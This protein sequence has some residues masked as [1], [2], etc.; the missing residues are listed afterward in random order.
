[1]PEKEKFWNPYRFVPVSAPSPPPRSAP[2]YH[3][4]LTGLSGT[5]ECRLTA[6]TALLVADQRGGQG[7]VRAFWKANDGTPTIPGTSLKGML[8]SFLEIVAPGCAIVADEKAEG[9][10]ACRDPRALCPVCALFGFVGHGNTGALYRGHVTIGDARLVAETAPPPAKWEQREIYMATPHPTHK[11]FYPGD[12]GSFRKLYH[13]QPKCMS[14]PA[15]PNAGIKPNATL[16]PA[17]AGAAFDFSIRF[18]GLAPEQL[19]MMLYAV[20]LERDVATSVTGWNGTREETIRLRGDLCHKLGHGKPVGLGS[21]QIAIQ[22]SI[23]GDGAE[24]Y[25]RGVPRQDLRGAELDAWH[26]EQAARFRATRSPTFDA[27]LRRMMVFDESDPRDF[28]YPTFQWF[29]DGATS[30]RRL[31]PA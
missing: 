4:R 29:H 5:L 1:M 15:A 18:V 3:H 7:S 16:Q 9:K 20:V 30:S 6:K 13:H 27:A 31:K 22:S 10:N 24:R 11:A 8:R 17:P 21:C 14:K 2:T 23:V 26:A 25:R 28:R 12:A 19:A